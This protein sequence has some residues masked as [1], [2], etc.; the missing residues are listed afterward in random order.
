MSGRIFFCAL[1]E[2]GVRVSARSPKFAQPFRR[3]GVDG[4]RTG[5]WLN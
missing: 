1:G 2:K 4:A 3:D 5:I